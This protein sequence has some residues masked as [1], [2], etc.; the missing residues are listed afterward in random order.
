D[1]LEKT[2]AQADIAQPVDFFAL[3]QCRQFSEDFV[4]QVT[5][6]KRFDECIKPLCKLC[7][8]VKANGERGI[9]GKNTARVDQVLLESA[10][11]CVLYLPVVCA[12]QS[13]KPVEFISENSEQFFEGER[14]GR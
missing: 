8:V 13:V 9:D 14:C 3:F 4:A 10:Q 5:V 12:F 11:E 7:R 6:V 1:L 2:F